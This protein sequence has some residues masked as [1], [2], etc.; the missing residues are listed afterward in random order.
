MDSK[1]VSLVAGALQSVAHTESIDDYY[2]RPINGTQ[3]AISGGN[4]SLMSTD[5]R[6]RKRKL[7]KVARRKSR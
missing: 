1:P 2:Q 3:S 5:K 4:V 7:Q 6:K